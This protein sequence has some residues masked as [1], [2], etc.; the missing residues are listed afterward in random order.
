[1]CETKAPHG[2]GFKSFI[3]SLSFIYS[4]VNYKIASKYLL[5][6]VG[7][8]RVMVQSGEEQRLWSR[9]SEFEACFCSAPIISFSASYSTSL[10]PSFHICKLQIIVTPTYESITKLAIHI[11]HR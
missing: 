9:L 8:T 6:L 4:F 11:K 10:C 3:H 7:Y 5:S 1:M 2:L